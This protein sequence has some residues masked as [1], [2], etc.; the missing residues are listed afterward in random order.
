MYQLGDVG[1]VFTNCF[2]PEYTLRALQSLE[3]HYPD[4]D[5]VIVDDACYESAPLYDYAKSNGITFIEQSERRGCG[6][7]IDRGLRELSTKL[8]LTV[9]HGIEIISPGLLEMMLPRMTT[10]SYGVGPKRSGKNCNRAFGPYIDPVF[11]IWDRSFIVDNDLSFKLTH[12]RIGN[13]AVEGCSTAQFLQ[14]RAMKLGKRPSYIGF[15]NLHK[16]VRHH[17]TP[18]D[19]GRPQSPHELVEVSEDYLTPRLRRPDGELV[20]EGDK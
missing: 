1:V 16:Y 13:W 12:I 3:R 9:D 2:Y 10:T 5:R 20:Y 19:R 14:Y 15:S 4:L 18:S 11:A 6:R 17:R 8:L 7:A